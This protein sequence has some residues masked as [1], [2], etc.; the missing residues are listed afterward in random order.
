MFIP[1]TYSFPQFV[2]MSN[3]VGDFKNLTV[4]K[5]VTDWQ[6]SYNS[7]F[8]T[9]NIDFA[10]IIAKSTEG[11][12]LQGVFDHKQKRGRIG[13][14]SSASNELTFIYNA[15]KHFHEYNV[16]IYDD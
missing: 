8:P 3:R 4:L 1:G 2:N 14:R 9:V 15:R 12:A 5:G 6:T 7:M 16:R 13:Y 11:A 10:A